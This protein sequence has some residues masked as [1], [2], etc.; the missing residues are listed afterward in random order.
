MKMLN[1]AESDS[2]LQGRIFYRGDMKS[3]TL[4]ALVPYKQLL[5]TISVDVILQNGGQLFDLIQGE[6]NKETVGGWNGDFLR[7]AKANK[8]HTRF[9]FDVTILFGDNIGILT[10]FITRH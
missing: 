1:P 3:A 10:N 2:A 5:A 7:E 4:V 9:A 8:S 6:P